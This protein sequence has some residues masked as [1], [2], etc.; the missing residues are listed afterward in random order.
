MYYLT[1]LTQPWRKLSTHLL[2]IRQAQLYRQPEVYHRLKLKPKVRGHLNSGTF[3]TIW[4]Q[5]AVF[6]FHATLFNTKNSL[7]FYCTQPMTYYA[8]LRTKTSATSTGNFH[9]PLVLSLCLSQNAAILP[10]LICTISVCTSTSLS[11]FS[12]ALPSKTHSFGTRLNS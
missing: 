11:H 1:F 2:R 5:G 7:I 6:R 8:D 3:S 12:L 10:W 4:H 9:T